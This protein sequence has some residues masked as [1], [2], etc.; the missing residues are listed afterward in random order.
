M[1]KTL[2]YEIVYDIDYKDGKGFG[3]TCWS[4]RVPADNA[5]NAC[6]KFRESR[7]DDLCVVRILG[8]KPIVYR[9]SDDPYF[10]NWR[11]E[12]DT[13][14]NQVARNVGEIEKG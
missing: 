12:I 13:F 10:D 7:G 11:K 4:D 1:E 14:R 5:E 2:F 3:D 9:G 6:K 8:V